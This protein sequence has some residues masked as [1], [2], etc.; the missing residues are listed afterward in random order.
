M[1]A[2]GYSRRLVLP[3]LVAFGVLSALPAIGLGRQLPPPPPHAVTVATKYGGKLTIDPAR[4]HVYDIPP[5][6]LERVTGLS[7]QL[8]A[9]E[10]PLGQ[11][12]TKP[13]GAT[14]KVLAILIEWEERSAN[15]AAHPPEAYDSLFFSDGIYPTGSVRD[16][17]KEV[18]YGAFNVIGGVAGWATLV[19]PYSLQYN[20]G[21]IVTAIDP[22]VNFADYDL[23]HDGYVDALWIIH[24]GTGQEESHCC[25]DIWS[26]AYIGVH[27]PTND[28]VALNGWSMQPER[29]MGGEII[30][31]RVF[32]H[33]YGHL[34]GMP[35]LYDYDGKVDTV[36][37]FT[38]NDN[39]DHPLVDW[40]VMGYM[41]YNIMSYGNRSCPSHFCGWSRAF[42]GWATPDVPACLEGEYTLYSIEEH[43]TQSLL[44]IPINPSGTEYFLLEYRNPRNAG[45]FDHLNSDFSAYCPWFTPG[46]DTLDA[47]LLITHID[48]NVPPNNGTPAYPHY[49]VTVEDAGYDPAHPWNGT[50]FTEW[51]YPYEFRIGAL[52]SPDDPGQTVFSPT[53]TPSSAGYSGPSG[54]SISVLSQTSDYMTIQIS[55]PQAPELTPIA[56]VTVKALQTK[57]VLISASDPNCTAPALSALSLPPYAALIDSGNGHGTLFLAPLLGQEGVSIVPIVASDG[58]LSDTFP[59]QI[60]V[61]PPACLCPCVGDP[62]CDSVANVQDV[63]QT[64]NVAFRAAA[65][66]FDPQCPRQR[67]DVNCDQ[68]T[69]VVDVVKTINVAFRGASRLTEFCNP[70]SP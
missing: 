66:V 45:L 25:N 50:E 70:C 69:T 68:V 42:L 34:L 13:L 24:A 14:G 30:S 18:S 55:K 57:E 60:T 51:W 12:V 35:D 54:I 59:V 36:T 23:D 53:T 4:F 44:K 37:Y 67:T 31:S 38:P 64:V 41:G 49:A 61:A 10:L 1:S 22:Y 20:I 65:P 46:R 28:G 6:E 47:G 52:F 32:C 48:E 15:Q 17:Y 43:S 16:Y 21:E 62:Q 33:E 39:N 3:G 29:H 5:T 63:V 27:V 8:Q 7:P 26:H 58:A 40:D 11:R 56:P 9:M 19:S 2:S